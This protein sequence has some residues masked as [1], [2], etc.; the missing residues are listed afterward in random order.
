M[1]VKRKKPLN[2]T[3]NIEAVFNEEE[4]DKFVKE[5]YLEK[6]WRSGIKHYIKKGCRKWFQEK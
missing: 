6:I 3:Q 4:L 2:W 1:M 5:G